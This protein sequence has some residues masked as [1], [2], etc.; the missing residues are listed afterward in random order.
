MGPYCSKSG[1]VPSLPGRRHV[2]RLLYSHFYF[3]GNDLRSG[4][5]VQLP[6]SNNRVPFVVST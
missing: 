3:L 1:D 6:G 5:P 4:G 2:F